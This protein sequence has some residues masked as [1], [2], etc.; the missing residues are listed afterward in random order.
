MSIT[1]RTLGVLAVAGL[2][3]ACGTTDL[4]RAATGAAI[5][6]AVGAATDADVSDSALYGAALGAVSCNVVPGAPNCY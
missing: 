4:E 1:F 3:T 6:G 2:L 5:G